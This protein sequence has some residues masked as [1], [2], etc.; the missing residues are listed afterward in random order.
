MQLA[1][2]YSRELYLPWLQTLIDYGDDV[3]VKGRPTKEILNAVSVVTAPWH[4][5][6][7]LPSRRWNPFLALSEA[8]WI[9]A[10]RNDVAALA[11]YNSHIT[12]YSD[13][14][15]TLY[16]AYGARIYHQID[17]LIERLHKDPNDRRAVL[18]IW[19]NSGWSDWSDGPNAPYKI[20]KEDLETESKDPPCNNMVYFKLRD[21]K[22]HMTVINRSNDIHYGL[23]A[24][25]LP[26]F[27]ILQSYIAA[28]LGVDMG[29]Q[30]H[31]S[32]SLHVYTD[33][34]RVVEITERML[35]NEPEDMPVYPEHQKIFTNLTYVKS[36]LEFAGWC[37]VIL[38]ELLKED[39]AG[40]AYPNLYPRFFEFAVKFLWA[41]KTRHF[42]ADYFMARWPEYADWILSADLFLDKVWKKSRAV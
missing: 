28:R 23:F 39:D 40:F 6:I 10:G 37:S 2:L 32:N 11:P 7:L 34:P 30:T 19:D 25:N 3:E 24:V 8:L 15:N 22:L 1:K 13:D 12:D 42:E 33:E 26:T 16:G 27:G 29:T 41:Y 21:N 38:D 14:G 35:Y 17:P 9:L 31:F 18:Q 36:H 4:H 5:C 20:C